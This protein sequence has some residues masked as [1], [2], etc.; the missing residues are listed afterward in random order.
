MPN[1][2]RPRTGEGLRLPG[3]IQNET[4]KIWRKK[5]FAVVVLI[6]LLIVPIFVYAQLKIAE[7]SA[8]SSNADW[9]ADTQSRITDLTN[10]L[11]SE[12]IPEEWK[13]WRRALVQQLQY[14]LDHDINPESPNAVTFTRTFMDNAVSLFIPLMVLAIASDLVSG[15]R[16]SGT[17]KLLLTRPVKRWRI[18]FAKLAALTLYV[19]LIVVAA[20]AICYAIAGLAFGYGGWSEPIFVGFRVVG[21][22]VDTSG[23]QALTQG[24]YLF[25]QAGLI[26]VSAMTVAVV[27]LMVSVLLRGTAASFVTMMAAIIAG[28]ILA[29]MASAWE[30]AKYL[31]VVNLEITAYLRGTPPP[32]DGMTLGFSLAVLGFWAVASLIVS[33]GV[34]TRQDF[35]N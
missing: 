19:S 17:I 22:E 35:M 31:F 2:R 29:G 32:I 7:S 18:L 28:T 30:N 8:R 20:V 16:S 33:F 23:V 3:L 1:V 34:F 9:R 11:G 4:L 13:K 14:Y 5:R 15:E 24:R 6:L 26:W 10:S 21:G 12:R 25:M 27:A